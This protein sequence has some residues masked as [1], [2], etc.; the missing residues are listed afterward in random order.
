MSGVEV[1]Q[2]SS[3]RHR[4]QFLQL[5]WKIY[6]DDPHWIPPLRVDQKELVGYGRHPF[7][8]ANRGQTLLAFKEGQPCGRLLAIV[9]EEHNRLY[10]D[11]RVGFFGFF[12]CIN[13]IEVSTALFDAAHEWLRGYGLETLRGPVNPSLNYTIGMLVEG[14][15]SSPYFMMTYNPA[16]YVQLMDA[17]GFEKQ[18]DLFAYW[19]HVEML[20][21]L[22]EK[23]DY[24][25]QA[26]TER[27]EI[28]IRPMNTRRF[29]EEVAM[30]LEIYNSSLV[31]TWGFV[32][33]SPGEI[34]HLAS[35]LRHLIVPELASVAEVNG[36]PIGAAFGILDYNPRIRAIDGRLFPFGFWRLLHN[37]RTIK[38]MRLISTNVVP[39]YQRWGVGLVLLNG[40]VPKVEA[41]DIE[42]V[43]FSW[44]LESN[45]LSR[46]SLERGGA[47]HSKTYRIFDHH[48]TD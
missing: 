6:R 38:N 39:E 40:L 34:K 47:K 5:P 31:G 44:V 2:V 10:P 24:V 8:E 48:A 9:N 7:F 43:E 22:D 21:S 29:R 17:Y 25:V 46:R 41:W 26:A 37:K 18:Q 1:I 28:D 42:E 33:L 12:E 4:K 16:Y 13:D 30:F 15:D 32:P 36:R 14:F 3:R 11:D 20:A 27:F 45:M 35:G 19:G 23:L